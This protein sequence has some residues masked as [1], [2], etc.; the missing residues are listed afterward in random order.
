MDVVEF[1]NGL[2]EAAEEEIDQLL[3]DIARIIERIEA[4]Q[5]HRSL[6]LSVTKLEEARHWL[7]DRRWKIA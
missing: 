7:K 4:L 3:I 1:D 5:R 6:S 2:T